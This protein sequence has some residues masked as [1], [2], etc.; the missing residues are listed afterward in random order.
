MKT[1]KQESFLTMLDVQEGRCKVSDL[2]RQL[3]VEEM[4]LLCVGTARGGQEES[5]TIGAASQHVPGQRGIRHP[6]CLKQEGYVI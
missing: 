1:E 4:T 5:S 6:N 3:T 2:V